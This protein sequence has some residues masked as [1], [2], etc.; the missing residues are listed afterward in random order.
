M[1]HFRSLRP[2]LCECRRPFVLP[3]PTA[4][5]TATSKKE[6]S[7]ANAMC[8]LNSG[9]GDGRIRERLEPSHRCATPLDRAVVLLDQIVEVRVRAHLDVP[10]ARVFTSQQPQCAPTRHMPVECHLALIEMYVS[11]TRHEVPTALENRCQRFSNSG[12]YRVTHLRI[13][14]WATSIP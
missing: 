12:T 13:V 8:Q 14:L 11:S 6:L 1:R 10:P 7:L 3:R 5:S 4:A 2:L 9:N